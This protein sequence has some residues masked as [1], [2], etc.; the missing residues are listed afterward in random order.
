MCPDVAALWKY[1]KF[2]SKVNNEILISFT[3]VTLITKAIALPPSPPPKGLK[4]GRKLAKS[5]DQFEYCIAPIMINVCQF[6]LE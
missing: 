2:S 3:K 1:D 5:Y 6:N 4:V